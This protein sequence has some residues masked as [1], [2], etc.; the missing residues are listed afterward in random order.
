MM[1]T[2]TVFV[3]ICKLCVGYREETDFCLTVMGFLENM[4]LRLLD[5][6]LY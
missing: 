5:I 2:E 6:S 3:C 1:P 4:W